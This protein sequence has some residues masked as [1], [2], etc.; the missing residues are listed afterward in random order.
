MYATYT[1]EILY[2]I[3]WVTL[4]H[5]RD[6]H[7]RDLVLHTVSH[8]NTCTRHTRKRSSSKEII[9]IRCN[10]DKYHKCKIKDIRTKKIGQQKLSPTAVIRPGNKCKA[11]YQ[12]VKKVLSK[13]RFS[14]YQIYENQSKAVQGG[15]YQEVSINMRKI[16]RLQTTS[17]VDKTCI[18]QYKRLQ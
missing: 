9:R 1:E 14:H 5:V 18:D 7:G 11:T 12:N 4:I 17:K 16:Y 15:Q 2:Y 10:N 6:I 8:F 13:R 3:Q